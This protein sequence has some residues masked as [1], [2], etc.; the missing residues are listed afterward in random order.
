M[1]TI[2]GISAVSGF[3]PPPPADQPKEAP[4]QPQTQPTDSVEVSLAGSTA[5]ATQTQGDLASEIRQEQ[6]EAAKARLAEGTYK[7]Q[8]TVLQVAARVAAIIE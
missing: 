6:V 1:V 4:E 2:Q 7:L 8:A 5:A 3:V